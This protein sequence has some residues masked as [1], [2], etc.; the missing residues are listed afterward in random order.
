MKILVGSSIQLTIARNIDFFLLFL[1]NSRDKSFETL[2]MEKTD[3]RGVDV[4]L[5]S[6][7]G[8]LFEASL[9]CLAEGGRFL[10]L[11]KVDFFSR[12][13]LDSHQFLRNCSFHGII[14]EHVFYGK[15]KIPTKTLKLLLA[16]GEFQ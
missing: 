6:L 10:E 8:E 2:I 7:A 14:L 16:E 12:K 4:V 11:G 1:G 3:G 15:V 13:L 9:R 5:N